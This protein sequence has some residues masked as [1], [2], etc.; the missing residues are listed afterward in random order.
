MLLPRLLSGLTG[1]DPRAAAAAGVRLVEA[2][3]PALP[4]AV[5]QSLLHT[6]VVPALKAA[7]DGCP[8]HKHTHTHTNS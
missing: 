4:P 8:T 3:E 5:F 1:W 7:V 6:A 2:W